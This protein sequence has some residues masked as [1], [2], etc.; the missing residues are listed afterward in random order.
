MKANQTST[1]NLL[2]E[3]KDDLRPAK[4]LSSVIAGTVVGV[5]TIIHMLSYAAV[6]FLE[7]FADY[8]PVA[9]GFL[10]AAAIVAG[11]II[12][13]FGS[14]R[15]GVAA[16]QDSP[17][18]ITSFIAVSVVAASSA[19]AIPAQ[20]FA[21][22]VVIMILATM[23][24]GAAF[25]LIGK[26][27][28]GNLIRF[29]PYPVIG[30]FLAGTGWL[31][32]KGSFTVM[33][34]V[35]FDFMHLSALFETGVPQLWATGVVFAVVIL[36]ALNRYDHFL[37]L[38]GMIAGSMLIFYF[39]LWISST[40][41]AQATEL[42]W[43]M[44][45]FGGGGLW[46]P[47]P[48]SQFKQIDFG[49]VMTQA[50]GIASIIVICVIG[51]L[52][53]ITALESAF[54]RDIDL[55]HELKITGM[56]NI[57]SSFT[58]GV[59]SFHSRSLSTLGR[60]MSG[61]SRLVG[62]V[63]AAICAVA[64]FYSAEAL[65]YF[66]KFVLGGIVMFVALSF[67]YDWIYLSVKRFN[68]IDLTIIVAI[69]FAIEVFGFLEGIALG[70]AVTVIQFV[71]NY[72]SINVVEHA[73]T[74]K[75]FHS[76]LERPLLHRQILQEKG[77]QILILILR[78]YIFFGS[79]NTLL[80]Q[81]RQRL[82]DLDNTTPLFLVIDFRN[83]D[84]IDISAA[85]SFVKL[86]QLTGDHKIKLI[87][88]HLPEHLAHHFKHEEFIDGTATVPDEFHD[89]D[90]ALEWCENQ[91][92]SKD[93]EFGEEKRT[94]VELFTWLF[95]DKQLA[96][97]VR[98]YCK[99]E[100]L[101]EGSV[102]GKQGAQAKELYFVE[103]GKLTSQRELPDGES[104]RIRT[105]GPGTIIGAASMLMHGVHTRLSTVIADEESTVFRLGEDAL[106]S[107]KQEHPNAAFALSQY[108]VHD[109]AERLARRTKLVEDLLDLD[110]DV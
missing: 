33:S 37:V 41:V 9:T 78:G 15:G 2:A 31:L 98:G 29:I 22:V 60:K 104:F 65:A 91:I 75:N 40:P 88:T 53:N 72:S 28:L 19:H 84:G 48:L 56:A 49:L 58:G 55:N 52:L 97:Q 82:E 89:I 16:P 13:L 27:K 64:L 106:E 36:I 54:H 68:R 94:P 57:A 20:S 70:I 71:I 102:L 99:K 76:N 61:E 7:N 85:H 1:T 42:G 10:L 74:A 67:L 107:M 25:F 43:L 21:A 6:I 18:A 46:H 11:V 8:I 92:L 12:A 3:L 81:V 35:V 101:E 80:D 96:D 62:L 108:L 90:H 24:V 45:P 39:W 63:S 44:K 23:L 14:L 34:D 47:I 17:T 5:L 103:S 105:I 73:L 86:K 95:N 110:I 109:L 50:G 32:F 66:P 30:G 83:V 87:Y 4:I 79:A 100:V 26:F 77:D 93:L 51:L 38:P 69:V 59:A